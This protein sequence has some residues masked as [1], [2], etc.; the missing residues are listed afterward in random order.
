[1]ISIRHFYN[2][3][4]KMKSFS[5]ELKDIDINTDLFE[6]AVL[7]TNEKLA[8]ENS[9]LRKKVIDLLHKHDIKI[10]YCDLGDWNVPKYL[11]KK[12]K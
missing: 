4:T 6:N 12:N 3:F 7:F 1:M 5:D 2:D 11:I 10:M 9:S 8:D